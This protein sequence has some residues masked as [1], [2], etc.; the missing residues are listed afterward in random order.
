[1]TMTLKS[2]FKVARE[3]EV[4]PRPAVVGTLKWSKYTVPLVVIGK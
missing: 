4:M 3:S 1:M 2:L